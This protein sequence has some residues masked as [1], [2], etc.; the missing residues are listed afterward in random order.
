MDL[1]IETHRLTCTL[2][3]VEAVRDLDLQVPRGRACALLGRNGAG[4]T[5]TI[6]LVAGLL[7]PRYGEA[8]VLG[9]PS[10]LLRPAHWQRIGY[11]S[12]NQELYDWMTGEELL[13]FLRP[14]YPTWDRDL[15]ATLRRRLA[16][17][18]DRKLRHCSRGERMKLAL[19]SS[20]AYRPPLLILDEPFTG[21]DVLVREELMGGL[22]EITAQDE[23]SILFATHDVEEVERLADEVDV[24]DEGRLQFSESLA[25]LQGRFR[26][27]FISL[28]APL[29][30]PV[31][32]E[33]AVDL[34]MG[35]KSVGFIHPRSSAAVEAVLQARFPGAQI[36]ASPLS[37]REIF[38]VLARGY[39]EAEGRHA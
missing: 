26:R 8:R 23:W 30:G 22:L 3:S 1:A 37:L 10:T 15:E 24:L 32:I 38:V 33:G 21:L 17:R 7:R 28:P 29:P 9:T 14:L 13:D 5:T 34:S 12:E 16:L 2:G 11:V 36:Q 19:A 18:L 25:D 4:K 20:L 31:E 6:K 35:D 39:Q 27:F